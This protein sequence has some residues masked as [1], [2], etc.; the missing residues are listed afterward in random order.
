MTPLPLETPSCFE[1][2]SDLVTE[3]LD[4]S[5]REAPVILA[6]DTSS[7]QTSLAI[8]QG[9][10]II[11]RFCEQMDE[12]RSERLWTEI[13]LLVRRTGM[14]FSD[15][16]L[17]SVCVGP[18][19][20][21]GL[22]VGIAA[23]KGFAFASNKPAVGVGSLEAIAFRVGQEGTICAVKSAYRGDVYAQL[24]D[25][26]AGNIP[27]PRTQPIVAL[28]ADVL[29]LIDGVGEVTVASDG[30][31]I[32]GVF[33]NSRQSPELT[34]VRP[35]APLAESIAQI[36]YLRFSAGASVKAEDLRAL[37]VRPSDA[38]TKLSKGLLGV[39]HRTDGGQIDSGKP[40][41]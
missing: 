12:Q 9:A 25:C 5:L 17:F 36:G 15:V 40:R 27:S 35:P 21:T 11:A 39:K 10:S 8:A 7:R 33:T 31:E 29:T 23:V 14:R 13:D 30:V 2:Q 28:P 6:I 1:L 4:N 22:R 3:Q 32:A 41:R 37:Y 20:F 19:G 38:E 34:G 16:E 26:L 18:G 24:F